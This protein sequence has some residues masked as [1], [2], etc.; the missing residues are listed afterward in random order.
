MMKNCILLPRKSGSTRRRLEKNRSPVATV[1]VPLFDVATD[2]KKTV[3]EEVQ[4][5][6]FSIFFTFSLFER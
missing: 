5:V 2:T 3:V 4:A 1:F 6:H